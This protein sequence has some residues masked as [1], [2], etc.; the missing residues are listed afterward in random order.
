MSVII[1][2]V[3]FDRGFTPRTSYLLGFTGLILWLAVFSISFLSFISSSVQAEGDT[4]PLGVAPSQPAVTQLQLLTG[5]L[6]SPG[7]SAAVRTF[8]VDATEHVYD[9]GGLHSRA[10]SAYAEVTALEPLCPRYSPALLHD[11]LPPGDKADFF[12]PFKRGGFKS[13]VQHPCS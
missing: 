5:L 2:E 7:F 6:H 4:S 9:G 11:F 8:Q 12:T 13:E 1:G 3:N 10:V